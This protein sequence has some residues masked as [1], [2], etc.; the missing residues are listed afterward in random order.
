M[1]CAKHGSPYRPIA[2]AH[3]LRSLQAFLLEAIARDAL[4][5][6]AA[7][8]MLDKLSLDNTFTVTRAKHRFSLRPRLR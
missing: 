6:Q 8:E 7:A 2:I 4:G 3:P 1:R 5:D